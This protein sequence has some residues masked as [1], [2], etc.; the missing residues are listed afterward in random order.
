[1]PKPKD[2]KTEVDCPEN[3]IYYPKTGRC[4]KIT[5]KS[6]DVG[7]HLDL[8]QKIKN[9]EIDISTL[10][11]N[12][13]PPDKII[14]Y[15]SKRCTGKT[16]KIGEISTEIEE[17]LT[18]KT[19]SANKKD[20]TK[21]TEKAKKTEKTEKAKKTKS[22]LTKPVK[23]TISTKPVTKSKVKPG[24]II[25]D[26]LATVKIEEV[27]GKDYSKVDKTEK[28]VKKVETAFMLILNE[29]KYYYELQKESP[30]Y[31]QFIY[32]NL[33]DPY[34]I[35]KIASKQEFMNSYFPKYNGDIKEVS[36]S[37]CNRE[38][39]ISPHQEFVKN[40][41]SN[42]TPYNS[43]LLYHGLGTGKTCSAITI[44]EELRT[45][46]KQYNIHKKI[47][48]IASPNVQDNFKKQLFNP[49]KLKLINGKWNMN[50]CVGKELLEEVNP[51]NNKDIKKEIIIKEIK[52]IIKENY[53]FMGYTEFSNYITKL[54]LKV[55]KNAF[56][57]EESA[58]K[59]NLIDKQLDYLF[60][61]E[62]SNRLIVIDEVHNIRISGN[63]LNKKVAEN[64]FEIVKHSTNMKLLMLSAT[65]MFNTHEEIIWLLNLMNM[66]DKRGILSVS[67]VFKRDGNFKLP[68]TKK[69]N[70]ENITTESGRDLLIRKMNGY[71]SFV[72]G[73]N[74][75]SFPYRV[76][77]S[78][79]D[80]KNTNK[81]SK[82]VYPK[83]QLNN[84]KID[85]PIKISDIYIS[86]LKNSIQNT[87]YNYIAENIIT[88]FPEEDELEQGLGWQKVDPLMQ[89]LNIVYPTDSICDKSSKSSKSSKLSKSTESTKYDETEFDFIGKRGLDNTMNYDKTRKNYSYN[90]QVLKKYGRIFKQPELEKY[91][92]KMNTIITNVSKSKG[93]S[94]IYSQYIDSG[95]V[96]LA[97]ALEE[98][99]FRRIDKSKGLFTEYKS[100]TKK[101]ELM[102]VNTNKKYKDLSTE[103][104]K[105]FKQAS[106]AMITG[107]GTLSPNNKKELDKITSDDNINGE[108]VKVVIISR[109]GSEGIDFKF[110]RQIHILDPWY[111]MSR[112]E[113]I[114]GRGVRY[115]SHSALPIEERNCEVYLHGT[116]IEKTNIEPMDMYIYRKAEKKAIITGQITRILKENSI[117]CYLNHNI[118]N[119]SEEKINETLDINIGS[120]KT[121]K[122]NVG[123]KPYSSL[124][125]YMESCS[126]TC[127]NN[128]KELYKQGNNRDKDYIN[129]LTYS[130]RNIDNAIKPII[131]KVRKIFNKQF[132]ITL[133]GLR[134]ELTK[135]RE[136]TDE[137]IIHALNTIHN[138]KAI[139]FMDIFGRDG[140]AKYEGEYL[141]ITPYDYETNQ[142]DFN[143]DE[144]KRVANVNYK[145]KEL[146]ILREKEKYT[147]QDINQINK[148]IDTIIKTEIPDKISIVKVPKKK[149][150]NLTDN[151]FL[152]IFSLEF[153]SNISN[154]D[155]PLVFYNIIFQLASL[156]LIFDKIES[157][158]SITKKE[159]NDY[160]K[161][162]DDNAKNIHTDF[163]YIINDKIKNDVWWFT[164]I[165]DFITRHERNSVITNDNILLY[166]SQHYFDNQMNKN[167][168]NMIYSIIQTRENPL[169]DD[170]IYN[171]SLIDILKNMKKYIK[172]NLYIGT[173][174]KDYDGYLVNNEDKSKIFVLNASTTEPNIETDFI[175]ATPTQKKFFDDILLRN[176]P[177]EDMF[178]TLFSF[179]KY[180]KKDDLYSFKTKN[181]YDSRSKGA[182]CIQ[183]GK[184]KMSIVID[185]LHKAIGL[186]PFT[187]KEIEGNIITNLC[188]EQE[189]LFR[190]LSEKSKKIWFVV[191]EKVDIYNIEKVYREK[192]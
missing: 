125:D 163:K 51:F 85:E 29:K 153:L 1:M 24:S 138:N 135:T 103:E 83:Y 75:Y 32:P 42:E 64:L 3:K 8:L 136:Y 148:Y 127:G 102:D 81:S 154:M 162:L 143:I 161:L 175:L 121:I 119:L 67:S 78:L 6:G 155:K 151:I 45:H 28:L 60:K 186:K 90:P 72:R 165:S 76:Y 190:K 94:I 89:A 129:T 156:K 13:C 114:I 177:T 95:C 47:M 152:K 54:I 66:N 43:L 16:T 139:Q 4:I 26:I 109:S 10:P 166:I 180:I 120:N 53:V 128:V 74:P 149:Q 92:H 9:K 116:K 110:I 159:L 12:N 88:Q 112:I 91:S 35:E 147:K 104:K 137:L 192:S 146:D 20:D 178:N 5:N 27:K 19:G 133:D 160:I 113:Q 56:D 68:T 98:Q 97:L 22:K 69:I 41:L 179:M 183:S 18:K 173:F 71:V 21:K 46:M 34:F 107:D 79:F 164:G 87:G 157:D 14:N 80:K 141:Y 37:L 187:D 99:G 70:G 39:E 77:P 140:Y 144:I 11:E 101:D 61:R 38:F 132:I 52:Q 131:D 126:Y 170:K 58:T 172:Q 184:K 82:Y 73:E 181:I 145:S 188:I 122:F 44:C 124:C 117:D 150:I 30:D 111:N 182:R 93:I 36:E 130:I 96:P 40:F 142:L 62:F 49:S 7:T 108:V 23:Q 118:S 65:P 63:S 33:N 25:D 50:S 55:T 57:I 105:K 106:Y 48:V 59:V 169:Y 115:C 167:K 15:I 86:S 189:F 191:P 84:I 185:V 134:K 2:I 174:R 31:K 17:Y 123:D 176:A 158:R 168:L 171:N 100:D